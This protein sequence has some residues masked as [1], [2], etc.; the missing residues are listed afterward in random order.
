MEGGTRFYQRNKKIELLD[1]IKNY[2]KQIHDTLDA[3]VQF[4]ND[5]E[6]EE[7]E[8]VK[9]YCKDMYESYVEYARRSGMTVDGKETFYKKVED[10]FKVTKNKDKVGNFYRLK[11]V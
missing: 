9:E 1:V 6:F 10:K 4:F 8:S 3:F 7:D 2:T 11:R 5:T